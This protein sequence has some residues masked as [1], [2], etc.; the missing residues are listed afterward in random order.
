LIWARVTSSKKFSRLSTDARGITILSPAEGIA[1]AVDG[2]ASFAIPLGPTISGNNH[3]M[4]TLGK[5]DDGSR[6]YLIPG[7]CV[8]ENK[9]A[10]KDYYRFRL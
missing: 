1:D 2:G 7:S 8:W 3:A 6:G 4:A 10:K 5:D 9:E